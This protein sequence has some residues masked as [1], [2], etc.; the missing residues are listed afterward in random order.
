MWFTDIDIKLRRPSW[1][2]RVESV[3]PGRHR[4]ALDRYLE[5]KTRREMERRHYRFEEVYTRYEFAPLKQ[6]AMTIAAW[7]KKRLADRPARP[8]ATGVDGP[9]GADQVFP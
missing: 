7:I 1:P 2:P 6:L 9:P 8:R 5:S 3:A 4:V